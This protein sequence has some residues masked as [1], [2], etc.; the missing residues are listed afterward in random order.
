[1]CAYPCL[2]PK[3]GPFLFNP[4][5]I[6]APF[7]SPGLAQKRLDLVCIVN[8]LILTTE[9]ARSM[10]RLGYGY[11]YGIWYVNGYGISLWIWYLYGYVWNSMDICIWIDGYGLLWIELENTL[12][13]IDYDKERNSCVWDMRN[14][15]LYEHGLIGRHGKSAG[16]QAC[17]WMLLVGSCTVCFVFV[18]V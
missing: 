14:F 1:M 2:T 10:G 17:L 12:R 7:P 6:R 11:G 13:L 3:L 18:F 16:L 5:M 4:V 8:Q 9:V 15:C